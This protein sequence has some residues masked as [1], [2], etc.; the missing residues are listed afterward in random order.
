MLVNSDTLAS[1]QIFEKEAHANIHAQDTKEGLS[2]YSMPLLS[3]LSIF[4]SMLILWLGLLNRA[5]T[6]MGKS[7][8]KRWLLQPSLEIPVIEARLDAVECFSMPD[9][10]TFL[11]FFNSKLIT[12][13]SMCSSTAHMAECIHKGLNIKN[14]PQVIKSL[15]AGNSPVNQWQ[16]LSSVSLKKLSY[17]IPEY[18]LTILRYI[19]FIGACITTR[20]LF[21]SLMS[22]K[23]VL[24]LKKVRIVF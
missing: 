1:L 19:Q 17:S 15:L 7:L 16:A 21:D 12:D 10:S 2:L 5:R 23:D 9:N 6:P 11:S 14:V 13:Y 22:S 4:V 20:D 8:L 24:V 3:F 18:Q